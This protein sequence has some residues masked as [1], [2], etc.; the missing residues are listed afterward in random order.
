MGHPVRGEAEGDAVVVDVPGLP[1][2]PQ[3]GGA[4]APQHPAQQ[5]H[6]EGGGDLA[7]GGER[8]D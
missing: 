6:G 4:Q 5:Q 7:E 1:G 8:V 2:G 3:E